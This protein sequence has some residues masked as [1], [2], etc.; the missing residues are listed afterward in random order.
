[1]QSTSKLRTTG[2]VTAPTS[3]LARVEVNAISYFSLS[4]LIFSSL[5]IFATVVT[6]NFYIKNNIELHLT[7]NFRA[8]RT[9]VF[10]CVLFIP[11]CR[12]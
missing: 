8:S 10:K 2:G 7:L 12:W 1:M 11:Y 6:P 4:P 9:K 5:F 3:I